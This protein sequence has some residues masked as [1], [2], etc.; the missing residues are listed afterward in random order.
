[1]TSSRE[2]IHVEP[3][4][5]A[6]VVKTGRVRN[7]KLFKPRAL[8][9]A[10]KA[11]L[12]VG[13]GGTVSYASAQASGDAGHE[14]ARA[15]R[16]RG[17]YSSVG[18]DDSK[19][20][21]AGAIGS[22]VLQVESSEPLRSFDSPKL[23]L[24]GWPH[25]LSFAQ[26]FSLRSDATAS[27]EL[28]ANTKHTRPQH[29]VFFATPFVSNGL[30]KTADYGKV[31][32]TRMTVRSSTPLS[33]DASKR[34]AP[35]DKLAG[36]VQRF[37]K[38]RAAHARVQQ[39]VGTP[40]HSNRTRRVAPRVAHHAAGAWKHHHHAVVSGSDM[41]T[42]RVDDIAAHLDHTRH[43]A[44]ERSL[45]ALGQQRAAQM[46]QMTPAL[47]ADVGNVTTAATHPAS[48]LVATMLRADE[49]EIVVGDVVSRS[50][51]RKPTVRLEEARSLITSLAALPDS[52]PPNAVNVSHAAQ[53]P[54]L[55]EGPHVA[56]RASIGSP[57]TKKT[58]TVA[59]GSDAIALGA[60]ASAL[61]DSAMAS[62]ENAVAIGANSLADRDNAVSV[63][64]TGHERQITNVGAATTRTDA[65][66]LGQLNDVIGGVNGR[67]DDVDRAARRGIAAASALNIATPYLPGRTTFNAG[68]ASYRGQAALGIG[69]SS[70]NRKGTVN[71]NLGVSTAGGNSTI[72][73]VGM[74]IVL[75][76]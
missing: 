61:G 65:I 47:M 43:D 53:R 48:R 3:A 31:F 6:G 71:Y 74:G 4:H 64:S 66:N 33:L 39:G 30:D 32:D 18:M 27:N 44:P 22:G 51:D 37:T 17:D 63:G 12:V 76:A 54:E 38:R 75:G 10:A 42:A 68:M 9:G 67:I 56:M 25:D 5:A 45:Y 8:T 58:A 73:R 69:V 70:W 59:L 26:R 21:K 24:R 2:S 46:P 20:L 62:G 72:V 35:P 36:H 28:L 57:S 49:P 52:T 41:V 7:V 1:M 16:T 55:A 40:M 14:N 50:L 19:S 29:A 15:A 34:R 13:F 60:H 11:L 23:H